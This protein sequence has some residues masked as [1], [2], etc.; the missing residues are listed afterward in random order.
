MDLP[1]SDYIEFVL[2]FVASVSLYGLFR[3]VAEA[4]QRALSLAFGVRAARATPFWLAFPV[5]VVIVTGFSYSFLNQR[6]SA[7]FAGVVCLTAAAAFAIWLV[8]VFPGV[9][10][11]HW[12]QIKLGDEV[13]VG[14]ASGRV[15]ALSLSGLCLEHPDG[16]KAY[17]PLTQ[18]WRK[19]A[20]RLGKT[21]SA[22]LSILSPELE[23]WPS[24]EA[25]HD[26]MRAVAFSSF[27]SPATE[28][29]VTREGNRIRLRFRVIRP[30]LSSTAQEFADSVVRKALGLRGGKESLT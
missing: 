22:E 17:V 19:G 6:V 23:G 18:V 13:R 10:F 12:S 27:V 1:F 25:L 16:S 14:D 26:I 29:Q 20:V 30:E 28:P 7:L 11:L 9:Q 15:T 3:P 4:G 21:S 24:D 2:L 8:Q 5:T